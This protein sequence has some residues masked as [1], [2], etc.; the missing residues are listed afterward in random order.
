M[1]GDPK[2][3]SK[4]SASGQEVSLETLKQ[5]KENLYDELMGVWELEKAALVEALNELAFNKGSFSVS[6]IDI[7]DSADDVENDGSDYIE[8]RAQI[9]QEGEVNWQVRN[10]RIAEASREVPFAGSVSEAT[11]DEVSD[12]ITRMEAI[13][14]DQDGVGGT[15][16][17]KTLLFYKKNKDPN[18]DRYTFY[19]IKNEDGK[20]IGISYVVDPIHGYLETL[21]IDPAYHSSGAGTAF[22][23]ELK[24]RYSSLSVRPI[25][26]TRTEKFTDEE[27]S[28][29]LKR[30]YQ[31][32]G[33]SKAHH[34]SKSAIHLQ[35]ETRGGQWRDID[36]NSKCIALDNE[37]FYPL[38]AFANVFRSILKSELLSKQFEDR[39]LELMGKGISLRDNR[40]Q[41]MT[42][43]EEMGR[44][45]KKKREA[46]DK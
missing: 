35:D 9:S 40:I 45:I 33:F 32:N 30:F 14:S 46:Q 37:S 23:S 17:M 43:Y 15:G 13:P 2:F 12:F 28:A 6:K 38:D 7:A 4:D 16:S 22:I 1:N 25:P 19:S 18:Y 26:K 44:E 29:K 42:R 10:R 36:F 8:F 39:Q 11:L 20:V 27:L 5:E 34:W 31:R 3:P 41:L 24:K 21:S